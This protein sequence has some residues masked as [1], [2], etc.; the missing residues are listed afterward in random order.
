MTWQDAVVGEAELETARALRAKAR[1]D[2]T[3][4]A[5]GPTERRRTRSR[6]AAPDP[7]AG[8]DERERTLFNSLREWRAAVSSVFEHLRHGSTLGLRRRLCTELDAR[9]PPGA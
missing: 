2:E 5:P 1:D 7:T 4:V 3:D 9:A 8:L 6:G